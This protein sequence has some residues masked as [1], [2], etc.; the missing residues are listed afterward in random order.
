MKSKLLV[1]FGITVVLLALLWVA[2]SIV[3]GPPPQG[4]MENGEVV[5]I[6][7][8][9]ST[10][11]PQLPRQMNYQ[12]VLR[13]ENGTPIDGSHDLT[14]RIYQW[15]GMVYP[16][17]WTEVYSETQTVLVNNGLFNVTIGSV[18]PLEP[19]DFRGIW[20]ESILIFKGQLQLG[21]SVDDEAELSPRVDLLPVPY[22]FRAEYVNRFPAPH[23]DSGWRSIG[24]RPDPIQETFTHSLGGDT[25]N[26]VVDLECEG[27]KGIYQCGHDRAYWHNLTSTSV[28]VW[29]AGGT[30][31]SA[32]HVRIW[33]I[34]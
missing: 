28:T 7:T 2:G 14:F 5:K 4:A 20:K 31:P 10:F 12:G 9:D 21:I 19:D 17:G 13:D 25:D 15:R 23:Y 24:I 26:Y 33:R 22:A 27:T 11:Y 6:A 1:I 34:D 32:I 8:Y 3:A 16:G 29:V 30:D 18:N